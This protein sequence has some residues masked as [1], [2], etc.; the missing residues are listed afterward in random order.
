MLEKSMD[1]A[2]LNTRHQRSARVAR[3]KRGLTRIDLYQPALIRTHAPN[4]LIKNAI[5]CWNYLYLEMRLRSA[6]TVQR[7]DLLLA[8]KTHSPYIEARKSP[9]FSGEENMDFRISCKEL[10]ENLCRV[11]YLCRDG[12]M[13]PP[14]WDRLP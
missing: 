3:H 14:F 1:E 10:P 7:K 9:W 11:S 8:I 6:D 13:L 4:R 12:P 5:N 2:R